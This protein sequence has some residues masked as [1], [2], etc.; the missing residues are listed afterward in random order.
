[1]SFLSASAATALADDFLVGVH[2]HVL[3]DRR[4]RR[5][6]EWISERD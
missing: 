1:M 2:V 4:A 6:N 5:L 3:V